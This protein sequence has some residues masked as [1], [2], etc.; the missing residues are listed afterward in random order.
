L[1]VYTTLY[2][3]LLYLPFT[4]RHNGCPNDRRQDR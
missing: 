2:L 1:W 4:V 3:T